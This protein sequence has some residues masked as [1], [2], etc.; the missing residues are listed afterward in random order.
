MDWSIHLQ[1]NCTTKIF[2]PFP[3]VLE[4][5]LYIYFSV[6]NDLLH[7][8]RYTN[9]EILVQSAV[10]NLHLDYVNIAVK[11]TDDFDD[12]SWLLSSYGGLLPYLTSIKGERCLNLESYN[13]AQTYTNYSERSLQQSPTYVFTIAFHSIAWKTT[14]LLVIRM[15]R[16]T[17]WSRIL[18]WFRCYA[19]SAITIIITKLQSISMSPSRQQGETSWFACLSFRSRVAFELSTRYSIDLQLRADMRYK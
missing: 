14:P 18:I 4:L 7:L 13:W 5:F 16:P 17:H 10:H 3:G 1:C 9:H 12:W 19:G 2:P 8:S 6:L 15:W 11:R